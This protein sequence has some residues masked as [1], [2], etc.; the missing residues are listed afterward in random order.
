MP[1]RL[2]ISVPR[3]PLQ[4][5]RNIFEFGGH[6]RRGSGVQPPEADFIECSLTTLFN[7]P[8]DIPCDNEF[9]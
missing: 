2:A 4:G 7:W 5:W 8:S 3:D 9:D 1:S 6:Q